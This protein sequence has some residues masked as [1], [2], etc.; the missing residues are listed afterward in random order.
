MNI[1]IPITAN[2]MSD[3]LRDMDEAAKLADII[4]LRIDYMR[5]PCLEKL[6][7]HNNIPKIVT[8]RIDREGGFFEGSEEQRIDYL[9]EA[10]EIGAAYVDIELD[11]FQPL[12]KKGTELIISHHNFNELPKNMETLFAR[13]L[14]KGADIVKI[15]AKA[16]TFNDSL[17]MLEFT[18][19][20]SHPVIGVCMGPEGIVTRILGPEYGSYLTFASL[21]GKPSAPGQ[22]NVNQ[23]QSAYL[24]YKEKALTVGGLKE[25][26]YE[27][28]Y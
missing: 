21:P 6:I 25:L 17:R 23:L 7:R 5:H 26:F 22:I 27:P 9:R 4:E 13:A 19:K 1:A 8:N 24:K 11:Y 28:T 20:S 18:A 2:N 14:D 15:A 12:E 16:N 3:A 10:I